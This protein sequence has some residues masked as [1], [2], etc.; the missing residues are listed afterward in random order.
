M[1]K[2]LRKFAKAEIINTVN[3]YRQCDLRKLNDRFHNCDRNLMP[4]NMTPA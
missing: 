1:Y 4:Y 3:V 2:Q